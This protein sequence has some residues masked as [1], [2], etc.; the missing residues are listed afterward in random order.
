MTIRAKFRC[1]FV[2]KATDASSMTVHLGAVNSEN[3]AWSLYTPGGQLSMN[4]SNPAAFDLFQEG[5]MYYL[6]IQAVE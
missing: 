2:Q 6:D 5:Q 3:E 4:I 1:H